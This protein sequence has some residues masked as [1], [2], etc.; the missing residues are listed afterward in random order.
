MPTSINTLFFLQ[1]AQLNSLSKPKLVIDIQ[2]S[3]FY[4]FS[5]ISIK[6]LILTIDHF[7]FDQQLA[8]V[9]VGKVIFK[10][11]VDKRIV[12]DVVRVQWADFEFSPIRNTFHY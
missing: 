2:L 8:V 9:F 12:R 10:V 11:V 5:Q 7:R 6:D 1:S 3:V 4:H